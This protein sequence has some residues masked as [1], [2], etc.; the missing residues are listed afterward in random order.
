MSKKKVM[1]VLDDETGILGIFEE[2]MG[3]E[4]E[5][6]CCKSVSEAKNILKEHKPDIMFLDYLVNGEVGVSLID[7]VEKEN[8]TPYL[9]FGLGGTIIENITSRDDKLSKNKK[10]ILNI[11][12][13]MGLKYLI[14]K[15][16][17]LAIE[18]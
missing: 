16:F 11:P 6:H 13:G 12:F 8:F 10:L 17:S 3:S 14:N 9:L 7:E 4:F 2:L 18:F 5:I 1:L 15:Q